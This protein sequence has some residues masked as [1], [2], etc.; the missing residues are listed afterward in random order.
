MA[1]GRW[2]S[3]GSPEVRAWTVETLGAEGKDCVIRLVA[4]GPSE[5]CSGISCPGMAGNGGSSWRDWN[6]SLHDA[7]A[8]ATE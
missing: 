5:R 4:R 3:H 7:N 8:E 1:D 2:R 6:E